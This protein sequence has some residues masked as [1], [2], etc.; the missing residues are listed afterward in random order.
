MQ[1]KKYI[2]SNRPF[3]RQIA[4]QI[5]ADILCRKLQPGQQLQSIR[6]LSLQYHAN[7]NTVQRAV[8]ALK[9]EQLLT[10]HRHGL[11]VTSNSDLIVQFR[12]RQC[13]KL[14]K[15]FSLK[16]E[17]LGYTKIEVRQMLQQFQ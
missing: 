1:T 13:D 10:K 12:Q 17:V 15:V 6:Q 7:P 11:F 16:M 9:R 3:Y 2:S 8:D 14:I 5:A 4:D